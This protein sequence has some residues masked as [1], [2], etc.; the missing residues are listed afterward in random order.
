MPFTQRLPE[1]GE[2]SWGDEVLGAIVELRAHVTALEGVGTPVAGVTSI[3][4]G[5]QARTG[6]V[7]L[8]GIYSLASHVHSVSGVTSGRFTLP[9]IPLSVLNVYDKAIDGGGSWP[10]A[11]PGETGRKNLLIGNTVPSSGIRRPGDLVVVTA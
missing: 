5:G 4:A 2:P 11:A 3:V 9:F 1:I 6:T 10:G 7:T 8:D